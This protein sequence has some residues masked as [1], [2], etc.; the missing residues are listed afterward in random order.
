MRWTSRLRQGINRQLLPSYEVDI[1]L[2]GG[3][4]WTVIALI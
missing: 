1:K 4:N 2:R 3:D